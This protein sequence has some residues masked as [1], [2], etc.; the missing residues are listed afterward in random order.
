MDTV[1]FTTLLTGSRACDV[2]SC[3]TSRRAFGG[4][5]TALESTG[6]N[7]SRTLRRACVRTQRCARSTHAIHSAVSFTSI[8]VTGTTNCATTNGNA[9][10]RT[11]VLTGRI[12]SVF[13]CFV[14][15]LA[16][17]VCVTSVRT[18]D[19]TS[20]SAIR[21]TCPCA[22]IGAGGFTSFETGVNTIAFADARTTADAVHGTTGRTTTSMPSLIAVTFFSSVVHTSTVA[23]S[24]AGT[25]TRREAF[26]HTTSIPTCGFLIGIE[27]TRVRTSGARI[28]F[29]T[30]LVLGRNTIAT[31]SCG[32]L[33]RFCACFQT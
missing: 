26:T 12:T 31:A 8:C 15:S 18:T 6:V 32:N 1:Y 5:S 11:S 13:T 33:D 27:L 7:A 23:R 2:T 25:L 21:R 30:D 14:L 29:C 24:R 4:T 17:A 10:L 28:Y 3:F 16:L 19:F 20:S 9:I 22:V